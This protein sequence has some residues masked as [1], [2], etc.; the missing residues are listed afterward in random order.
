MQSCFSAFSMLLLLLRLFRI[1]LLRVQQNTSTWNLALH[2]LGS[3]VSKEMQMLGCDA[4]LRGVDGA[5]VVAGTCLRLSTDTVEI[6][7]VLLLVEMEDVAYILLLCTVYGC[8]EACPSHNASLA[9]KQTGNRYHH[10]AQPI[11]STSVPTMPQPSTASG[12]LSGPI[13]TLS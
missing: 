3:A 7:V 12:A 8:T 10:A 11:V 1:F 2:P 9:S 4:G 13:S 5:G 6:R